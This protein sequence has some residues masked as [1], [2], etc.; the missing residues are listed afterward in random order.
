VV[1]QWGF[2]SDS[3]ASIVLQ[4]EEPNIPVSKVKIFKTAQKTSK[5][6]ILKKLNWI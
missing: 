5:K 6:E 1:L 2:S 3:I 4:L